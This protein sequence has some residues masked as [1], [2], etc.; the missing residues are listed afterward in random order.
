M[1][2]PARLPCWTRRF[3]KHFIAFA[4]LTLLSQ[5]S[6]AI[7]QSSN[8]V[9]Q[10]FEGKWI[11]YDRAYSE[12]GTCTLTFSAQQADDIY[13][14]KQSN[15]SGEIASVI[16]WAIVSNQLVF[17]GQDKKP[18]AAVGGNQER[19]SGTLISNNQPVIFEKAELAE[20][21]N[22]ARKSISCAYVGYSRTCAKP[23]EFAPPPVAVGSE[24]PIK[25]LVNLN[26]RVE[27]RNNAK[28][29]ASLEPETCVQA[30]TCSLA[31]DGLWC[32]VKVKEQQLWIKKQAVR[33]QK[34]PIITFQNGCS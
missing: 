16:G 10:A 12:K 7:A 8:A 14:I 9:A 17:V 32:K 26:A 19:L 23:Q 20:K 11:T 18:L 3:S 6:P 33:M 29:E 15:C 1:T 31:S 2:S 13:P 30:L 22:A 21:I 34:Y 5:A 28:V 27:P 24:A 4:T 25:V